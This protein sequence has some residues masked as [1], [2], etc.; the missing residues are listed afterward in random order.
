[1]VGCILCGEGGGAGVGDFFL[2]VR[3]WGV[4]G[5]YLGLIGAGDS[6]RG[7]AVGETFHWSWIGGIM[8]M[9]F[10]VSEEVVCIFVGVFDRWIPAFLLPPS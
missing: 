10:R 4:V 9:R 1:M 3:W 7:V 8:G 5:G 2:G 6:G